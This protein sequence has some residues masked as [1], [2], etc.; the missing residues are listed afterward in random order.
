MHLEIYRARPDVGG[1]VHTHSV[2]AAAHA[3]VHA[4]VPPI[5][6]ELAQ[7]VGGPVECAEYARA[8]TLALAVSVVQ[9]LGDRNAAL[10][11]NHGLVGVGPTLPKALRACLVVEH[12]ARIHAAAR[13][14]GA[15]ALLLP[16]EVEE[17]HR[18]FLRTYGQPAASKRG[19]PRR[20]ADA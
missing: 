15:P 13:A 2:Y 8:G 1:V 6:E 18:D 17:L 5:I 9:A 3:A 10:L 7:V 12:A 4:S 11:A 14:L 19:A 16:G 20:H